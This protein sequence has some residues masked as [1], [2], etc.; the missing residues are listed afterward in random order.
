MSIAKVFIVEDEA[1]TAL[2]IKRTLEKLN[3]EIVG[4]TDR[5]EDAIKMVDKSDPDIILMDITLKGELDGIETARLLNIQTSIPIVYLTAHFDDETIERSKSTIPYGFLLKPLN[6]RDLNSCLRMALFRFDAEK[7]LRETESQ[8]TIA[9][10]YNEV[11]FDSLEGTA[12]IINKSGKITAINSIAQNEKFPVSHF[13]KNDINLHQVSSI[14][15][16]IS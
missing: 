1:I 13:L 10:Q 3:Y 8:L 4:V 2:D 5:G 16:N 12:I 7:K 11:L 9:K 6:D 15:L 14:R